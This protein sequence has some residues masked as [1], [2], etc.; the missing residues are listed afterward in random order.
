MNKLFWYLIKTVIITVFSLSVSAHAQWTQPKVIDSS[1]RGTNSRM[2]I[3]KVGNL[4]IVSTNNH[5]YILFRSTD[6][7]QTFTHRDL[8]PPFELQLYSSSYY[9][10]LYPPAALLYDSNNTL[11]LLWQY[12]KY[13]EGVFIGTWLQLMRSTSD[14][15]TFDVFWKVIKDISICQPRLLIDPYN[16]IHILYD[17]VLY[18]NISKQMEVI[19]R[20]I[21]FNSNNYLDRFASNLPFRDSTSGIPEY[22][23]FTVQDDSLL[24]IAFSTRRT[25]Q[26]KILYKI[27]YI[28]SNNLGVDFSNYS[29][30]DTMTETQQFMPTMKITPTNELIITYEGHGSVWNKWAMLSADKGNTFSIPFIFGTQQPGDGGIMQTDANFIYLIYKTEY[31]SVYNCFINPQIQAIDSAFFDTMIIT[32]IAIGPRREK[33]IVLNRYWNDNDNIYTYFSCKGVS[34]GIQS[35]YEYSQSEILKI[36]TVPNPFNSTTIIIINMPRIEDLEI[37]IY[38]L[39]GKLV[40]KMKYTQQKSNTIRIKYDAT[41]LPSGIYIVYAR[42]KAYS[43]YTKMVLVK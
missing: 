34:D 26:G 9:Y 10:F 40:D 8:P 1:S 6:R 18:N 14:G 32:D 11:W 13:Y 42:T 36:I 4:A 21:R 19:A 33:Y 23:D 38:N 41:I 35:N 37:E 2:A 25:Y 39:Q 7:G 20:Y 29:Y 28:K 17:T 30:L 3:N 22:F 27:E 15:D 43:G 12:D 16:N 24:H 31:G 5:N